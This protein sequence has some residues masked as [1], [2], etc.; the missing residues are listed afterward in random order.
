MLWRALESFE[1]DPNM[2]KAV[3]LLYANSRAAIKVGNQMVNFDLQR[4]VRQGDSMSPVLFTI[5]LQYALNSINWQGKGLR[6][7]NKILSYLAY[8]DDIVLL[9]QNFE[10]LQGMTEMLH[11]AAAQVGLQINFTKTKWMRL[12][13]EI[14]TETQVPIAIDEKVIERANHFVYL[15]QKLSFPRNP[16]DEIRHRIQAARSAYFKYRLFLRQPRVEMRL[17]R[18][19]I[20]MCILPSLLYGCETWVWTKEA[21]LSLRAAQRRLER[22]ILGVRLSDRIRSKVLR[23]RTGFKDWVVIALQRKWKYAARLARR[24]PESTWARA[25]TDWLPHGR[26][27]VG[28]PRT[29]WLDDFAR[30]AGV[31]SK[32][33]VER[34]TDLFNSADSSRFFAQKTRNTLLCLCDKE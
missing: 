9:A 28:R 13:N 26:R 20:N 18:K 8:A 6:L 30:F 15:G 17:K 7:G 29:R 22:A 11:Q 14:H 3:Q 5:V 1:V 4:G 32:D 2:I 10:D 24:S 12:S 33:V 21:A 34:W 31:R 23:R 25:A 16:V 27:S 19:L